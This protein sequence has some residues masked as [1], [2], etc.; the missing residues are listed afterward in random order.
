MAYAVDWPRRSATIEP[1]ARDR[2][3]PNQGSH[4][5]NTW[6]AIPVPRVSV[7]NSVRNPIRPRAGTRNSSRAQPVPWL[8]M[9]SIRPLRGA[10]SEVTAPTNS[11]GTS[12]LSRST[13]STTL[14]SLLVG[15]HLGLA[16]GQLEALAAHDLDE[17]GQLEL[18]AGLD[19]P[20]VG[21]FGGQHPKR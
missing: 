10:S 18:A 21:P 7:R 16:D 20:G 19:L 1:D 4:P 5:S 11:S 12:M 9:C 15:E 13:G 14:P 8:P 2:I 17:H 6:W 3:S